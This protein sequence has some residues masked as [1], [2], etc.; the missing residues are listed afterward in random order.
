MLHKI[1][2]V[3]DAKAETYANPFVAQSTGMAIRTFAD[4]ANDTKHPIGQHPEDY[5][6]FEIGTFNVQTSEIKTKDAK[7]ALGT[8]I[9]HLSPIYSDPKI[10]DLTQVS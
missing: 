6:L 4:I 9:E 2:T 7:I 10:G 1:F 3:F 5:T 8:A